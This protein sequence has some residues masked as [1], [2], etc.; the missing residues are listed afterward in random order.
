MSES[1]YTSFRAWF[2]K[3]GNNTLDWLKI[4]ADSSAHSPGP[5][6]FWIETETQKLDEL[7]PF[8]DV[9]FNA[10]FG[11]AAVGRATWTKR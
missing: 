3:T 8:G 7:P 5:P 11:G 4:A 2:E 1:D 6:H 9:D 10:V